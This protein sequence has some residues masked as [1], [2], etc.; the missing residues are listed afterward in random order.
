MR[1]TYFFT[2]LL[3]ILKEDDDTTYT[4]EVRYNEQYESKSLCK[5]KY[6]YS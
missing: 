1:F 4:E 6:I 2:C 3:I 5:N